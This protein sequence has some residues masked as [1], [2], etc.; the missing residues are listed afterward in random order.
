MVVS[1]FKISSKI[2][3]TM[4]VVVT[5]TT[6]M[7]KLGRVQLY[8]LYTTHGSKNASFVNCNISGSSVSSSRNNI[9]SNSNSNSNDNG[10]SNSNSN[11]NSRSK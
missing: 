7:P 3:P 5:R 10:N 1:L 8:N 2:I 9:N 4:N 11:S 6:L